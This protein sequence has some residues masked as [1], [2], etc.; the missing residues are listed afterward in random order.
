[1]I[2]Q[3]DILLFDGATGTMIFDIIE[4]RSMLR[5]AVPDIANTRHPDIVEKI[6]ASYTEAGAL[7]LRTNTFSTA[8]MYLRGDITRDEAMHLTDAAVRLARK[9]AESAGTTNPIICG[10][11]GAVNL[12]TPT[13]LESIRSAYADQIHVFT[14]DG[15]SMIS[16]ETVTDAAI[17]D[18][19]A[20]LIPSGI[21]LS[22]T[23]CIQHKEMIDSLLIKLKKPEVAIG[24]NCIPADQINPDIT[25]HLPS[26]KALF[27]S[28]K[29]NP[30]DF[31]EQIKSLIAELPSEPLLLGGCCGTTPLHIK[32]LSNLIS[33]IN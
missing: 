13:D 9:G 15:C 28:S 24:L 10:T 6:A 19:V 20:P 12:S 25:A 31:A 27:P 32:E 26:R 21:S 4:Q 30:H 22:V 33:N 29:Q 7:T 1:M 17:V 3:S 2:S 16:L 8:A 11:I 14:E 18:L 23:T 5:V